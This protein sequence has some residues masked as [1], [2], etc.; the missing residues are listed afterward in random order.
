MCDN[1][2]LWLDRLVEDS[3]AGAY[4]GSGILWLVH[5][6]RCEKKRIFIIMLLSTVTFLIF[7]I[8]EVKVST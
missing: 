2:I 6:F 5:S 8:Q 7:Y 1:G 3:R 4:L